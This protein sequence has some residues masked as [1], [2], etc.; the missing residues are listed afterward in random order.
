MTPLAPLERDVRIN[1]INRDALLAQ[2][3]EFF[4]K[5]Y[6]IVPN[7]MERLRLVESMLQVMTAPRVFGNDVYIVHVRERAPFVQLEI[8]RRDGQACT[9][10]RE[11]QMIKNQLVG[12]ECEGIELFPAESR[13]VDTAHQYHLWVHRDSRFRF[14]LGYQSRMVLEEPINIAEALEVTACGEA[15]PTVPLDSAMSA[16]AAKSVR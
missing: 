5:H 13:L 1:Q 12:P 11:F 16:C 10:W 15:A 3:P 6:G 4:Q 7:V 2:P 9:N 8:M 14:P